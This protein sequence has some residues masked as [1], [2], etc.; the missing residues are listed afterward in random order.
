MP[1]KFDY[2][3]GAAVWIPRGFARELSRSGHNYQ[4]IGRVRDEV[5]VAQARANLSAIAHRIKD[6]YGKKVDLSDA[7]VV[8][9]ADAIVGNVR[10]A[11]LTLMGAVGLLLLVACANVAGLLVARTSTRRKE[12]AVRAALGAGRGR[13]IQQLLAES[14]ALALAGG[15]L[16]ILLAFWTAGILPAILPASLPKQ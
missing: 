14:L 10:A 12:L 15:T 2:P 11:L 4:C 1:E 8:P 3:P 5:T 16:G 7:A 13:L 9:L 6:E